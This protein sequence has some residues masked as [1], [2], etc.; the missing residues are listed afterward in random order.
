MIRVMPITSPP[1]GRCDICWHEQVAGFTL[2]LN[3]LSLNIC[4]DCWEVIETTRA[5]AFEMQQRN[6]ALMTRP[7]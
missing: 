1:L 2:T 5:G 6:L 7:K 4:N 3:N